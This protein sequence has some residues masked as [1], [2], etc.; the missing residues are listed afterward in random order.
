VLLAR[1]ATLRA[2]CLQA[3][4]LMTEL[5]AVVAAET[6]SATSEY[7]LLTD[8]NQLTQKKYADM[9]KFMRRLQPQR[10][11]RHPS[12]LNLWFPSLPKRNGYHATVHM[13]S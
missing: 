1:G 10:E 3:E 12:V 7:T 8:M 9:T 4:V 5:A 11:V 2:N 13:K 6:A